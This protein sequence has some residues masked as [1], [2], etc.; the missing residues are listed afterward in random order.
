MIYQFNGKQNSSKNLPNTIG[1][2]TPKHTNVKVNRQNQG[3]QQVTYLSHV[4]QSNKHRISLAKLKLGS[5]KL[6]KGWKDQNTKK[7]LV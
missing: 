2:D 7:V 6:E 4:T 3:S 1:C 5:G